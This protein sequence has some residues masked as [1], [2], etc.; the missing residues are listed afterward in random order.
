MLQT[1]R[2]P[3]QVLMGEGAAQAVAEFCA[4]HG[5]DVL[6]ITDAVMVTQPP[7]EAILDDVSRACEVTVYAEAT[8]EV[9][10]ADVH[11]AA[12]RAESAQPDVILAIGG[13][14]VIDLAKVV[15]AV[16]VHGGEPSDYYGEGQVPGPTTPLVAVPTTA[17]TGSEVSPVAVVSDPGRELKVG[18]SSLHLIPDVAVIDPE[19]SLTCPPAVTAHA[20]IDAL[21]HAV[22]SYVARPQEPEPRASVATV[23]QG[24]N[25]TT[26]DAAVRATGKI[27]AHLSRAVHDSGDRPARREMAAGAAWAGVAFSHAGTGCPHALQYA[28]GAATGTPHG[29]GVGLLLPYALTAAGSVID[30][31]VAT[32]GRAAGLD[33]DAGPHSPCERFAQWLESLLDDIGVPRTLAE[34]GVDRADLPRLAGKTLRVERLLRNHPGSQTQEA[35]EAILEA[36]WDGD[37]TRLGGAN[38]VA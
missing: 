2:S 32:L 15:G 13:G 14:S 23:F 19:L 22:E 38:R 37:R 21:C 6:V 24:R 17:G 1:V 7:V 12:A 26:D 18:L 10:L 27:G 3:R 28:V 16:L 34:L 11:G 5:R 31:R 36:A 8:A 29:V 25:D 20:G 4:H 35:L 9:P 33:M 30:E